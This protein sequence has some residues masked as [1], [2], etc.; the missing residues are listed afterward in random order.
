MVDRLLNVPD[1][2]VAVLLQVKLNEARFSVPAAMLKVVHPK[3]AASVT[4]PVVLTAKAAIVLPIGVIVPV[5]AMVTPK[6][7]YVPPVASVKLPATV[8]D[9]AAGTLVV[10][11]K[12]KLVK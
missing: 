2:Y 6:D 8:I 1:V 4:V 5:P 7:V 11:V 9:E 3:A 12:F 10:P